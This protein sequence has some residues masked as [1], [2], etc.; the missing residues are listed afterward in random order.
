LL[1]DVFTVV[2]DQG[3]S[4]LYVITFPYK[5]W[6]SM[7]LLNHWPASHSWTEEGG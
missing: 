3:I 6:I 2:Y 1:F 7:D 5:Q 4:L